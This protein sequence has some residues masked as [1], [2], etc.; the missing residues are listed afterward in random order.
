ME[1]RESKRKDFGQEWLA[2]LKDIREKRNGDSTGRERRRKIRAA[3][4]N[5]IKRG[6]IR[7]HPGVPCRHGHLGAWY[8][9]PNQDG[10]VC[11]KCR[12]QNLLNWR[13]L[14]PP[15]RPEPSACELCGKFTTPEKAFHPDY[16]HDTRTFRGW[17]C[18]GCNT[19]IGKLGDN[20]EGLGRAI[21]YL[22]KAEQG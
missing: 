8:S 17:L 2:E 9:L 14:P 19:G 4:R 3:R 21:E 5:A 10:A 11:V 7:F 12:Q 18:T 20:V 13:G 15:T 1:N 22:R 6:K 16:D